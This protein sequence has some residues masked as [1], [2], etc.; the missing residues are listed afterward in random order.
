MLRHSLAVGSGAVLLAQYAGLPMPDETVFTAGLLHDVGKLVLSE[1][2]PKSYARA[3]AKAKQRKCPLAD[4]EREVLGIDHLVAGRRL[5]RRWGLAGVFEHVIWLH[6]QPAE[7][8]PLLERAVEFRPTD[9]D[10]RNGLGSAYMAAGLPEQAIE[11]FR[12]AI[13]LESQK[14]EAWYNL[15][16]VADALG[17]HREAVLAYQGFIERAPP[18]LRQPIARARARVE[19]LTQEISR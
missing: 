2:V 19:S 5:A 15:G 11:Q 3:L 6:H 16:T 8:I 17:L 13:E 4:V 12:Y 10:A 1:V 18:E 14:F 7:A 9:P